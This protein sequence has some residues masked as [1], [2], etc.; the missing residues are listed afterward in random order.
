MEAVK[1]PIKNF[2]TNPIQIKSDI[3][4]IDFKTAKEIA[5]QKA[6]EL[7]SDP[8]LPAWYQGKTGD[9]VPK[10]ECGVGDKPAW[11]IY[12]ESRGGDIAIDINDEEYI[13][14]F[15]SNPE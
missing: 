14:I 11:L 12:A 8:M 5:D 13:F 9:F 1:A 3:E 4:S 6:R 10:T 2:L 7:C 15:K